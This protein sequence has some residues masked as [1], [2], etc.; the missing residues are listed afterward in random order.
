MSLVFTSKNKLLN[1][2]TSRT[3]H[4]RTNDLLTQHREDVEKIAKRLLE[5]EVLI[6]LVCFMSSYT[7]G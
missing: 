6:R 1:I 5:K 3:A 2:V 7:E 4:Q